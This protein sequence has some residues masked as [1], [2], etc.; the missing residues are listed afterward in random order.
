MKPP[1]LLLA[2]VA[3]FATTAIG[4]QAQEYQSQRT[5]YGHLCKQ[6]TYENGSTETKR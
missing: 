3:V 6:T 1:V 5:V 2:S 4:A